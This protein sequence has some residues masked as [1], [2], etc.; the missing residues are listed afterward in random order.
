LDR[1]DEAS[2]LLQR[3]L[4]VALEHGFLGAAFRAYNNLS[5]VY[6]AQD[7]VAEMLV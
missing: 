4:E 7:R 2:T 1:L 5:V 6:E 3:A